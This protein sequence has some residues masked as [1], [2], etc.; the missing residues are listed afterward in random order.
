MIP[1]TPNH[2]LWS[3]IFDL[4]E[5]EG[6]TLRLFQLLMGD[7]RRDHDRLHARDLQRIQQTFA[8]GKKGHARFDECLDLLVH[9]K[10]FSARAT[11]VNGITYHYLQLNPNRLLV[12]L[13]ALSFYL[14]ELSL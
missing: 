5:V 12:P 8:H 10:V 2:L 4:S 13:E 1:T 7:E 14:M 3:D 6:D 9:L 11:L